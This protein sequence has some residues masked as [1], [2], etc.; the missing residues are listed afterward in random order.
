MKPLQNHAKVAL[1]CCSNGLS[2]QSEKTI[3]SLCNTLTKIGLEVVL[4]P[5]LYANHSVFSGTA[6]ERADILMHYYKDSSIKGI[7]D[8]SG[9]DLANEILPYLDFS[10]IKDSDKLFWGY[11][12]LTTII[13]A[14]Y[15]KTR[16]SSILYQVR[17]LVYD[18]S[19]WQTKYFSDAVYGKG[20]KLFAPEFHFIRQPIDNQ[21][22]KGTLVGGNIRC[23]LKLA[24][25]PYFPDTKDTILFLESRSG[26]VPQM[27]AFF[28]QLKQ[29]GV[30][31]HIKALLLGTFTEMETKSCCPSIEEL[32][33]FYVPSH[34]P[35]A[36][37]SQIGHGTD[38]L[39]LIIGNSFSLSSS[40][41]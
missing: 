35:I 11:S 14:I 37:T 22:I 21:E 24:G 1:V 28:S 30:L 12:D 8:V 16:R 25:T 9:G 33:L 26:Q 3:N 4:S 20:K 27:V 36:K 2:M 41:L 6:K 34:I 29:M 23:L 32:A 31:E 39:G 10:I 5:Y 18:H 15:A 19:E 7:L 17:N 38:S 13:N 40:T